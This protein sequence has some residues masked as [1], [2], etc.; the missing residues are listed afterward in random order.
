MGVH[1]SRNVYL[2]TVL[3]HV[4]E[5]ADIYIVTADLA[6]PCFDD[7]R[8]NHS[9]RYVPVG[10]A[11]QNLISVASGI[12]LS[13]AIAIAYASN[14]FPIF[15]GFDQIRNCVGLMDLPLTIVGVGAGFSIPEYGATHFALED[16]NILRGCAHLDVVNVS[17]VNLAKYVAEISIKLRHPMY[18]RFDKLVCQEYPLSEDDF[19]K[20]YRWICN[21][22][23][24]ACIVSTG[25]MVDEV[26][27][28]I[29][30]KKLDVSLVDVFRFP[31]NAEA[32]LKELHRYEKIVSV[33]EMIL[34]GGLGSS[35]LEAMSDARAYISLKRIGIDMKKGYPSQYGS[36]EWNLRRCGITREA[37]LGELQ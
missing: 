5:G 12:C 17:D 6:A 14:P 36:R 28:L 11:E 25:I 7:F 9:D 35:L 31:Y 23:S 29:E 4:D 2:E 13:G 32:L 22:K 3:K 30:T 10:I 19:Q 34:Q 27:Q 24:K 26:K 18:V 21:E 16:I 1:R 33:E 15:R 37:I 20:G 8:V